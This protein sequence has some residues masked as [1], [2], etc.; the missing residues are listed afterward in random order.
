MSDPAVRAEKLLEEAE[1][2]LSSGGGFFTKMLGGSTR[3]TEDAIEL[4]VQAAN[5]YKIAKLW[6]EAGGA[7]KRAAALNAGISKHESAS[8]YVEGATA[9]KKS[10]KGEAVK[11]LQEAVQVND[12]IIGN[13]IFN[14]SYNIILSCYLTRRFQQLAEQI[15]KSSNCESEK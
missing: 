1:K 15:Y 5:N 2:K 3:G 4:F 13:L 8:Q 7:F 12:L 10:D 14:L 11:C 9:F 6:C